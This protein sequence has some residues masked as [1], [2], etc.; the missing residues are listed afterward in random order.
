MENLFIR[1]IERNDGRILA[2]SQCEV[3]DVGCVVWD[4]A[5]VLTK[6]LET[7]DFNDG[8]NLNNLRIVELGS[9]TGVV[10]LMA[11]SYG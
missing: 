10:G 1:E 2:I 4:A 7:E 3:G 8:E 5:L 6:Y 9:G 11:A